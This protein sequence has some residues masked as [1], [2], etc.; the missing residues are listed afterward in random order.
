MTAERFRRAKQREDVA[1]AELRPALD[2]HGHGGELKLFQLLAGIELRRL[3]Q[4]RCCGKGDQNGCRKQFPHGRTSAF[5]M[6]STSER[7]KQ[8]ST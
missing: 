7:Q 2:L 1:V 3:R 6:D 4:G 8:P 5:R